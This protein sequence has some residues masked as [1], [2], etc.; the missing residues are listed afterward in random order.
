MAIADIPR[1][2][3]AHAP[4]PIERMDRLGEQVGTRHLYIKRDDCTGLGLGGNKTRKLEYLMADARNQGA[5]VVLTVGGLQSNHARQTAAAAARL[6]LQCEL[7]LEPVAGT[8]ESLY[9]HS[10]N[11]LLD[12]LFGAAVTRAQAGEDLDALLQQRAQ[13]HRDAG[14]V[15]YVVPVGGSNEI[16]S[17][18]YVRCMEEIAQW[19]Y[20]A[21]VEFDRIVLATGSAG[22]QAGLL[23][24]ARLYDVNAEILG[25]CVSRSTEDQH[26]LVLDLTQRL[27]QS[28]DRS[29]LDYRDRV[30]TDGGYVGPGYGVATDGM[31]QAVRVVAEQ[32]GILLDPVYT[33]KAMNGLIDYYR[34]GKISP[35]ERVLFL[36]TGGAPALFAYESVL[37]G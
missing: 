12:H 19:Q 29:P 31:R 10:G 14:E 18:G 34:L 24:G 37:V 1:L 35:D 32:E 28:L 23:V 21:D 25:F 2:S 26:T 15:P 20:D 4:T 3:L 22:T 9:D 17:L 36:H 33:G 5:T 27:H 8:P 6:G 30:V 16:G 11:V 7:V 13:A